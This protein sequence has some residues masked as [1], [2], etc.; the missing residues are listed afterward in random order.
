LTAGSPSRGAEMTRWRWQST[1][2][3]P[4]C[5][6]FDAVKGLIYMIFQSTKTSRAAQKDKYLIKYL[7]EELTRLFVAFSFVRRLEILFT[8]CIDLPATTKERLESN[9]F[10]VRGLPLCPNSTFLRDPPSG[11]TFYNETDL[12]V[13]GPFSSESG[14]VASGSRSPATT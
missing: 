6:R 3:G 2:D 11:S 4:S 1:P 7:G 5:M 12:S 13:R 9:I 14:S 8:Y 10:V